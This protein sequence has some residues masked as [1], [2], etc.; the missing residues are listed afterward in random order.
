MQA[1]ACQ[2][3][4]AYQACQMFLRL[5]LEMKRLVQATIVMLWAWFVLVFGPRG[6]H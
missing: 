4:P 1:R 3:A 6:K 5:G 2:A